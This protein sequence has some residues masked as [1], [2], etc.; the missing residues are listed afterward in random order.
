[1]VLVEQDSVVVLATGISATSW[2]LPVLPDTTVPRRDVSPLLPVLPQPCTHA[3]PWV[4]PLFTCGSS[5][6]AKELLLSCSP[7]RVLTVKAMQGSL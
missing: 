2:M 7:R 6:G 5:Y 1:M 4:T 3:S